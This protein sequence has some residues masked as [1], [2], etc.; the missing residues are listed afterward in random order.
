MNKMIHGAVRRDLTR[1]VGALGSFPEGDLRRARGLGAA[2][3]NFRDQLDQHHRGEH[4]IAWPAMEAV[5]VSR[6]LLDE[7]DS[8]H[9][10]MAAALAEADEQMTA[11]VHSGT[12]ADQALAAMVR[13]QD[14]T[15]AHLEHEE[16]ETEPVLLAHA[17]AP[18]IKEMSR[19]FSRVSP[20]RAGRFFAW[21]LDGATPEERAQVA[22]TVPRPV[23][24]IL[25][26]VFGLPYRRRV[27][28]VWRTGS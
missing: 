2:W 18:E 19:R 21:L 6:A 14:V 12:G 25:G 16:A 15:V 5:G 11:L 13:L 1:F 10:A 7:M 22:A 9:E 4:E 3:S 28:P 24:T 23:L 27:A 26:G 8:E 20:A 17:D